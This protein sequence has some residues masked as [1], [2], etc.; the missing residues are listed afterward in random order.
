MVG[1][2]GPVIVQAW[3][4]KGGDG[5]R[6][7]AERRSDMRIGWKVLRRTMPSA[8][9]WVEWPGEAEE[10]HIDIACT[11][12][13]PPPEPPEWADRSRLRPPEPERGATRARSC[14]RC[15]CRPGW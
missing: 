1:E 6:G 2:G 10:V 9:A 4:R 12:D 13:T 3:L 11:F 14:G 7:S 8:V 15:E 5:G